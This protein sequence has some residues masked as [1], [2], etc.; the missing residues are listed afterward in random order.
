M[1]ACVQTESLCAEGVVNCVH[2]SGGSGNV[3]ATRRSWFFCS[4]S[5]LLVCFETLLDFPRAPM[6]LPR[7]IDLN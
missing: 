6:P 5:A 3:V 2:M 4:V 7:A 1:K